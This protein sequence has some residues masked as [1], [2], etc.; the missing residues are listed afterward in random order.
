[1]QEFGSPIWDEPQHLQGWP[2]NSQ[3]LI[4]WKLRQSGKILSGEDDH[5]CHEFIWSQGC[6]GLLY[7]DLRIT[8]LDGKV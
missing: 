7:K 8:L 2:M 3:S 6:H 1:M 5:Y 4:S